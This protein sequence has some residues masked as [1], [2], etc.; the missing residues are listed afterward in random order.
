MFC[1]VWFFS[2]HPNW[3]G[4]PGL[5]AAAG[6]RSA[7]PT[8]ASWQSFMGGL[9]DG[10][11][12]PPGTERW[13][14]ACLTPCM[15]GALR[16]QNGRC[17]CPAGSYQAWGANATRYVTFDFSLPSSAIQVQIAEIEVIPSHTHT[18][19]RT[20]THDLTRFD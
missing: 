6:N 5:A 15:P 20:R 1:F 9:E 18:Y 2:S 12:C 7:A 10:C 11:R 14:D 4:M 19:D 3:A 13:F 8:A 16:D 17:Q